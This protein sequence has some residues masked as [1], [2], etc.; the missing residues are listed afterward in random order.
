LLEEKNNLHPRNKHRSPY[1][2]RQLVKVCPELERFVGLNAYDNLSVDFADPQAVKTLNKALLKFFYDIDGWDIPPGYLCPA[3][4]GRA[5]YIHYI[6]DLL[7]SS[8]N[9]VVP[10][11][12]IRVLDVGAGANCV[13]PLIGNREYGWQFTGSDIDPLALRYARKTLDQNPSLKDAVELRLQKDPMLVFR[14]IIAPGEAFDVSICNP[15]FHFSA[16]SA[17][18]GALKK[19]RNLNDKKNVQPVRNFAGKNNELWCEGGEASFIYRMAMESAEIRTSFLWF[20]T[21]VSN[22]DNLAGVYKTLKKVE[23]AEVRTISMSQGQKKSRMVAWTFLNADEQ[24]EWRAKR[25]WS[26]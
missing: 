24:K 17:D 8:N 12:G 9:G 20:T 5:D 10:R 7:A 4:P 16:E 1:D 18:A 23:A 2:F 11:D 26:N 15:P 21:L 25:N 13:Y 14:G 22:K 19:I 6:S 3:I